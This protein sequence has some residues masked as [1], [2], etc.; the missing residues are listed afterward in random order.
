MFIVDGPL[1]LFGHP[2]WLTP[3]LRRELKRINDLCRAQGFGL[4]VFGY[5][6]SGA[7]V[8]HFERL[9]ASPERGPRSRHPPATAFGLDAAYINRNVTLRPADAKP[10]GQDTYFGRKVF[11]KTA[12]G[13][14]QSSLQR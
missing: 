9:D 5:E 7:F 2:A 8:E 1:A 12:A 14:T 3:Y 4:A 11:Y 13:D 10:H 6:K